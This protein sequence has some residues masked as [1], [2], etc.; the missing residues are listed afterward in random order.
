[1]NIELIAILVIGLVH[2]A[3]WL[4][5]EIGRGARQRGP[6][7]PEPPEVSKP[8]KVYDKEEVTRQ[9]QKEIQK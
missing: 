2:F 4:G 9:S 1:M 3:F 6:R 5:V 7:L 8:P